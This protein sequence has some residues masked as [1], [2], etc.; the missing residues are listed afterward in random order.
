M[1]ELLDKFRELG[2]ILRPEINQNP[3]WLC[4][5]CGDCCANLRMVKQFPHPVEYFSSNYYA[6][7]NPELFTGCE[8]CV[9]RCQMKAL[10]IEN[11]HSHVNLD[12]CIG[13]G[14]CVATCENG[15][16]HS[17]KKEKEIVPPKKSGCYVPKNYDEEKGPWRKF[18]NDR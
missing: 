1:L 18:K 8:T 9:N 4:S 15:A 14:N 7:V 16:I 13:C 11:T 3:I 6:E 10:T 5:C 2:L 17:K 12:L